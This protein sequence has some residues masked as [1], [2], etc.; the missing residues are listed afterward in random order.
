MSSLIFIIREEILTEPFALRSLPGCCRS[1]Y[2]D[3]VRLDM[4]RFIPKLTTSDCHNCSGTA[5]ALLR[6]EP[7]EEENEDQ[8]ED[9]RKQD[10]EDH[11][12]GDGYS[13]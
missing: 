13:E 11:E 9:D 10:D 7:D 3:S 6:G 2:T 1:A 5:D 4:S 12:S 8:D